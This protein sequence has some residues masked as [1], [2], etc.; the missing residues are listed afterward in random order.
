MRVRKESGLNGTLNA[1]DRLNV[2]PE[3]LVVQREMC[4]W[5]LFKQGGS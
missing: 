4:R 2:G 1:T 5:Y 3:R